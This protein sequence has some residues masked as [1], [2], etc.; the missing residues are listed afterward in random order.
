V[1]IL[2]NH[3]GYDLEAPKRAVLQAG[4]AE[5]FSSQ[6]LPCRIVEVVSGRPEWQG[7]ARYVGP[8][9]RWKDWIFWCVD[10]SDLRKEGLY[11]LQVPGSSHA[12][13]RAPRDESARAPAPND[14]PVPRAAPGTGPGQFEVRQGLLLRRTA[15][16][17]IDYFRSQR[18]TG[19]WDEADRRVPF[20][21]G[22]R[23][24]VDVHG[25]WY[26]ASGDKSKYLSH[27]SY[28]NYMNPQQTPMAVWIF[29]EARELL[30]GSLAAEPTGG[31]E[32][33][34][35]TEGLLGEARYGADFL[36]RMQDP[37][38]YFY[39]AVF[40][41]WSKDPAQRQICAYRTQAGHKS[42]DYQAGYRQGGGLAI[43]ALARAAGIEPA[44]T[45]ESHRFLE[46]ARRGFWH[47]EA[48]N[49]RY[50][51]D[52]KENIIDDY[53]ALLAAT[54]LYRAGG[55]AE[56]LQTAR[57]RAAALCARL[58][59]DGP[60][61]GWWRADEAGG[62]PFFHAAEAGLPVIA[63]LRYSQTEP[64]PG[65]AGTALAVATASLRFEVGVTDE[66][67]NPFGL[68]RQYVRPLGGK[69]R[70]SFFMPHDN[71]SGY[72][73]QGE[74]ARLGSLSSAA[75]MG[76]AAP[77][78]E[79]H[80]LERQ[81]AP[82]LRSYAADQL[83]WILGLN[84]FDVCMLHG[85]GRNN[86]EYETQNPNAFGG[87]CNGITGGIDDEEDLD[88]LPAP[89]AGRGEH[90]WRWSEQW[91]PHAAWYLLAI[92]AAASPTPSPPR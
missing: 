57:G 55:R 11:V 13:K 82:R 33:R 41:G 71:E 23:D 66:V 49:R 9:S 17:V 65:A 77:A 19:V 92:C 21:G 44:A 27:L 56:H 63:L 25:G 75:L 42:D 83:N 14:E 5:G 84:P 62:R 36:L 7:R 37:A 54:E 15:G 39:T 29:L 53:C 43:A 64:E 69:I 60:D 89:H 32:M 88:F 81:L 48:A 86:P 45:R 73:W 30:E 12:R 18:C 79:G 46:A 1:N 80:V 28:A 50:L 52:G 8:V 78:H 61:G 16:A 31:A 70:S 24:R 35:L 47:L 38:G 6:A 51:D 59:R 87:V 91:I 26:D 10:F 40:D 76:I 4:P 72:W 74:N 22:R 90:R 20:F 58:R 68:A 67:A 85:F 3:I 2:V 34:A